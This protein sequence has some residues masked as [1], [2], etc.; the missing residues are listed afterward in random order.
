[1]LEGDVNNYNVRVAAVI[2]Q[3]GAWIQYVINY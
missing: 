3:R 1:M 2:Q